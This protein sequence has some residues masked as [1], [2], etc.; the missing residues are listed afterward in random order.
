MKKT[1]KIKN[2]DIINTADEN[3]LVAGQVYPVN[4]IKLNVEYYDSTSEIKETSINDLVRTRY[5]GDGIGM[6]AGDDIIV[7]KTK[8]ADNDQ[9]GIDNALRYGKN[10]IFI[11]YDNTYKSFDC[12][13]SNYFTSIK[14]LK[15]PTNKFFEN[16]VFE[17]TLSNGNKKQITFNNK[18]SAFGGETILNSNDNYQYYVY[19]NNK[20]DGHWGWMDRT[21]NLP[22][23]DEND[24]AAYFISKDEFLSCKYTCDGNTIA[25][26]PTPTPELKPTPSPAPSPTPTPA[27]TQPIVTPN[28]TVKAVAK[29][30]SAKIKKVKA[31]KKA[32]SVEW[33]K[34][35]GV[36][37]YQ[38][39]VATDKKFKK[40]KK[41]A[42]VKKQKTT[43]VTI[44]KL[45]AKKKYY[46]RIRTYKT[47]NGK[48]VY[49]SWSK[50]KTVK[51]K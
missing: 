2:V 27:P 32:V 45:K 10:T 28:T 42:T 29:P 44:K 18:F 36:K 1:K 5:F 12:N 21:P 50:V 40:N 51:T 16:A 41:T 39:Q 30:K 20:N 46:V 37:G 8:G 17:A 49:S 11:N 22:D 34:V 24:M 19:L 6:L 7:F 38:V 25:P 14:L 13:V 47:V 35:S 9:N 26:T 3:A 48:K 23:M 43:K 4:K 15:N 31:A 33:K